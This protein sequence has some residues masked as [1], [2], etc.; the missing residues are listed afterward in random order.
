MR[1]WS[2]QMDVY[3]VPVAYAGRRI[4]CETPTPTMSA[5]VSTVTSGIVSLPQIRG[6][7]QTAEI[8]HDVVTARLHVRVVLQVRVP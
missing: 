8:L 7:R 1:H 3:F 4:P 6:A 5:L 2:Y